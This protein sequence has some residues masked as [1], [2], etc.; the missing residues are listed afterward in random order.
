MH[1][2]SP[3]TRGSRNKARHSVFAVVG[4]L[5]VIFGRLVV[6]LF[7]RLAHLDPHNQ[8]LLIQLL[9]GGP[10]MLLGLVLCAIA[11]YQIIESEGRLCGASAAIF[12]VLIA[13]YWGISLAW[14]LL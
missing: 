4:F 5:I 7:V 14:H 6:A 12:G 9:T 13:C 1:W 3:R 2:E 8:S 11:L 10:P